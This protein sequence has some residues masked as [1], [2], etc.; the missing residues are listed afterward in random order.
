MMRVLNA[1]AVSIVVLSTSLKKEKQ[2][3]PSYSYYHDRAVP[4]KR[5]W[6]QDFS[7]DLAF[8]TNVRSSPI[9]LAPRLL[10]AGF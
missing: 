9:E 7:V 4:M 10:V 3:R 6:A 1:T 2:G 8:G 5:T